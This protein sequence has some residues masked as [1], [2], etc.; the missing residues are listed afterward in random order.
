MKVYTVKKTALVHDS[1][2]HPV[3]WMKS[4]L[5]QW[6]Q[7]LS[8]ASIPTDDFNLFFLLKQ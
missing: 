2:P 8:F 5:A 6:F 1:P 4:S 7:I 3:Y